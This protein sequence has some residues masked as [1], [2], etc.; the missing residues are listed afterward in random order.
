MKVSPMKILGVIFGVA[1]LLL[2]GLWLF[3]GLG[4]V[5]IEPIACVGACEPVSGPAPL[6]VV[7]GFVVFAAGGL[8]IY[9]S[10]K[11]RSPR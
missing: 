4:L 7:I 1:G 8:A 11:R 2:G 10:L 6:W 9:F 3:Q 5:T